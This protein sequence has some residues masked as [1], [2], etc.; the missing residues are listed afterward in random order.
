M[1][2]HTKIYLTAYNIPED[3]SVY[4]P[5]EV[6]KIDLNRCLNKA[7]DIH[8]IIARGMGGSNDKDRIENIMALCRNCHYDYGDITSLISTL[9]KIHKE[10]LESHNVTYDEDW[11][12]EQIN[13]FE[14]R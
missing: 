3:E 2:S 13:K 11:I 9:F 8:H 14:D 10:N 5:C 4:I 12:N 6:G 7:T 1:K